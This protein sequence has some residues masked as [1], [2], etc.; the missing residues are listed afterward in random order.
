LSKK[1]GGPSSLQLLLHRRH[2]ILTVNHFAHAGSPDDNARV[3]E[4]E[5]GP[6]ARFG[7][8]ML[9]AFSSIVPAD[10]DVSTVA[11]HRGEFGLSFLDGSGVRFTRHHELK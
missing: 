9:K 2:D 8:Q 7:E 3:A 10:A 5:A 4:Y 11:P 6:Y 1:I